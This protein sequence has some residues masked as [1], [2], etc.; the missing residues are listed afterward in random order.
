MQEEN[1]K[2]NKQ[3]QRNLIE[4]GFYMYAEIIKENLEELRFKQEQGI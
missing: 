2:L 1:Y 3:E 4:L